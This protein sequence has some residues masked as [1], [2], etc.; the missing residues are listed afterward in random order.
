RDA[1]FNATLRCRLDALRHAHCR[2]I[3]LDSL[4]H[5]ALW[6]AVTGPIAFHILRRFPH[7]AGLLP[8]HRPAALLLRA[9]GS[10]R[11]AT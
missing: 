8:A 3:T 6:Q 10:A 9:P 4:P 5:G 7:W 11:Q 1:T 2:A